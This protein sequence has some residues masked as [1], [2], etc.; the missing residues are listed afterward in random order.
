MLQHVS[1][2]STTGDVYF[3]DWR[4]FYLSH[5]I[6]LDIIVAATVTRI[7][8]TLWPTRTGITIFASPRQGAL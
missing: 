5:A 1:C 2:L 3:D 8:Y 7:V 6:V 4:V